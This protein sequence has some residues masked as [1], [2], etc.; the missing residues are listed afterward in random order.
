VSQG[1]PQLLR[2]GR[3]LSAYVVGEGTAFELLARRRRECETTVLS[4]LKT[5]G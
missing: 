5:N 1:R 4:R 2:E 3:D